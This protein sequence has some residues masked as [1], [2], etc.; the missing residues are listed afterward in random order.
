MKKSSPAAFAM[1]KR[2]GVR[3]TRTMVPQTRS[4]DIALCFTLFMG[5]PL[6]SLRAKQADAAP[7]VK[8]PLNI[9]FKYL[10]HH[11]YRMESASSAG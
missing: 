1:Q 2:Q 3:V 4:P 6:L 10:H 8:Y 5:L 9:F 7:H 11:D